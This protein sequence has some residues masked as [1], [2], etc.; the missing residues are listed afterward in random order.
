MSTRLYEAIAARWTARGLIAQF[1]GNIWMN[2]QPSHGQFPYV[3]LKS[4]GNVPKGFDSSGEKRYQ[5]FQMTIFWKEGSPA[6]VDPISHVGE[7]MR[8]L[9]AA[10]FEAPLILPGGGQVLSIRQTRDDV[11]EDPATEGV[12]QGQVDYRCLRTI[13]RN[14]SPG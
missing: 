3:T 11:M 5:A 1:P 7:L 9:D 4:L 13:D 14:Y 6:G 8:F 12:W 10:F 2:T